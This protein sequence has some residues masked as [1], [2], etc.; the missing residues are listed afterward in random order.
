[1][2]LL[3]KTGASLTV[4][5]FLSPTNVVYAQDV[6]AAL[7]GMAGAVKDESI[8][9]GPGDDF[10][11]GALGSLQFKLPLVVQ[12]DGMVFGH[13][14]DSVSGGGLHVGLRPNDSTYVGLYGSV[15]DLARGSGV[16]TTRFGGELMQ[17]LGEFRLSSVIGYEDI[18]GFSERVATTP[19]SNTFEI[20]GR[21]GDIFA[22]TDL[23]YQASPTSG[24]LL[25]GH[26]YTGGVH[27]LAVGLAWPVGL[28]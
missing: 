25:V 11:G 28:G 1:M 23:I 3:M 13:R 19:T 7:E 26:R 10:S 8:V 27:A 6:S 18:D 16:V 5:T 4:I 21:D 9:S 14:G 24:A 20:Y 12:A 2:R 15:S 17:E 22:F